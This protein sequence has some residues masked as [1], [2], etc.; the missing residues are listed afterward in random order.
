MSHMGAAI[1]AATAGQAPA[2]SSVRD[3]L[4]AALECITGHLPSTQ[5]RR[6]LQSIPESDPNALAR[7]L[8]GLVPGRLAVTGGYERRIV[9]AERS[10]GTRGWVIADLSGEPLATRAGPQWPPDHV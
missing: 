1:A 3:R 6:D 7:V 5:D 4:M 8:A 10:P 2:P 9:L